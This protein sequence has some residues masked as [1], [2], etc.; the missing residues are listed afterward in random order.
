[1]AE[2]QFVDIFGNWLNST[3]LALPRI[4]MSF[5]IL[6]LLTKENTPV[7][8][9]NSLYL[10]LAMLV[11]PLAGVAAEISHI[12]SID[13]PFILIK[14]MLLGSMIGMLFSSIFW[15]LNMAGGILDTQAGT[16]MASV[17]DPIQ[18]HQTSLTSQWLA[19]FGAVLFMSSG[20]FLIFI[21]LLFKS[22]I[23]WPIHELAP[24]ISLKTLKVFVDE[25]GYIFSTAFLIAA[26]GI[27]ILSVIDISFGII[28]R[29]A[30]QI[31]LLSITSPIKAWVSSC[32]MILSL[33]MIVEIVLKKLA[34]NQLLTNLLKNLF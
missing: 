13:W 14:E 30:Q 8:V 31:N 7:M 16:N 20:A 18:G 32:V 24:I 22:Y 33:G 4:G 3:A 12:N 23:I 25:F 19:Q 21:D 17:L 5:A 9:R 28:N 27:L 26:P 15:A 1:M 6:P 29:F 10:S 34:E 11:Y 2:D